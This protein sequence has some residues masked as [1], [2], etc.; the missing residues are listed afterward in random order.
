MRTVAGAAGFAVRIMSLVLRKARHQVALVVVMAGGLTFYACSG[1]ESIDD[2]VGPDP[3]RAARL[4]LATQPSDATAGSTISS[5]R[6]AVQ[7]NNGSRVATATNP[8]SLSIAPN[9]EGAVLLGT[10]T[11]NAVDGLATFDDLLIERSGRDYTLMAT[12]PGLRSDT[13]RA[14]VIQPSAPASVP[15][16]SG[17]G[18]VSTVGEVLSDSLVARVE[19]GYGNPVPNTVVEWRVA[20]GEGT[21]SPEQALSDAEGMAK[22]S[23]TLGA[24]P[25]VDNNTVWAI[26]SGI[27][28]VMFTASGLERMPST[29]A[30]GEGD[31][32]SA[33]AGSAVAIA[34]VALVTDAF[35]KPVPDAPV[36]FRVVDGGGGVTGSPGVT[37]SDGLATVGSWTLGTTAGTNNNTLRAVI[38]GVDSVTLTASASVGSPALVTISAG[39]NQSAHVGTPV[40][41]APS[42]LVTDQF[43]NVV[44]SGISVEFRVQDGGGSVT[45]SP[46]LTDGTGVATV[47]A[48]ELGTTAGVDNNTLWAVLVG[49]D[50]ALVTAS[51]TVGPPSGV[52]IA[53][54][55]G[56]SAPIGTAV[57]IPPAALVTDEFDNPVSDVSVSFRVIDGGGSITGT[58]EMTDGDGIAAV[59]SWTLGSAGDGTNT[60]RAVVDGVDSVTYVATGTVSFVVISAGGVTGE[61][62]VAHDCG[63]T[64]LPAVTCWG[65][66]DDGQLGD[67][68]RDDSDVPVLVSGEHLFA[69]IGAGGEHT[70]GL[71]ESGDIYCWGRNAEGQLGDGTTVGSTDPVSVMGS[72]VFA[73]VSTGL[74][75]TCGVTTGGDVYCWGRNIGGQ[76]GDSTSDNSSEPVLVYGDLNFESVAAGSEH[77]CGITTSDDPDPQAA[78]CWGRNF[79]GELGNGS[80]PD[81]SLIPVA[82]LGGN[83]FSGIAAG[84]SHTCGVTTGGDAYCWGENENGELGDGSTT[85][86]STPTLVTGG[87]TFEAITTGGAGD[88]FLPGESANFTCALRTDGAVYCWGDNNDGQLGDGT[89]TDS[90]VPVAV[91]GG[92]IFQTVSAGSDHA[93]G[94]SDSLDAYCWGNGWG[95]QPTLVPGQD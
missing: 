11:Q 76:L 74:A 50:S 89:T 8:V 40:S 37:D 88:R 32:Q 25:G 62:A 22:T 51:A 15:P 21:T 64:G 28:S 83:T 93:C 16:I 79:S 12:A 2:P 29:L 86:R 34:P 39:D 59:G 68:T 45:G 71:D 42:V 92:I 57:P 19:D 27:D 60:L 23:W 66:N 80:T 72:Q 1:S 48:W 38:T 47:G 69:S 85:D 55:D 56:Q 13:S 52:A 73:T 75:H 84:R 14:F 43:S 95:T 87:H 17:D 36:T 46:A 63:I 54:G 78:Y 20:S 18:Q 70:C 77:S 31:G 9:P 10:V 41:T 6:V 53:A 4:T 90:S 81:S 82:A 5:I 3:I 24:T 65:D 7:D 33:I 49:E 30:I 67:G 58:P 94:L 91:S 61:G 35:G 26:L 44:S